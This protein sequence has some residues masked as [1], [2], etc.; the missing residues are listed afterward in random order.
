MKKCLPSLLVLFVIS[1][2]LFAQEQQSLDEQLRSI[3]KSEPFNIAML[4]QSTF[5]YS[6]EDD[7]F[8]GGRT[9]QIPQGRLDF[10]GNLDGGYFY[11]LHTNMVTEPNLLDAYV[12]YKHNDQLILTLGRQKP[13]Q[14]PDFIPG[15]QGTDFMA[16]ARITGFLV[17]FRE[18][19]LSAR[20][21][22]G[23][24]TYFAGIFNG[25]SSPNNVGNNFYGVG[26]LQYTFRDLGPGFLRLGIHGGHGSGTDERA[27]I[28]GGTYFVS[29]RSVIGF[30]AHYQT[31]KW[32]LKGEYMQGWYNDVVLMPGFSFRDDLI[33]GYYIN[34]AYNVS[35]DLKFVGRFQHWMRDGSE[36]NYQ[37][38]LGLIYEATSIV[39]FRVNLDV[40]TPSNGDSQAG[41]GAMMQV[42]F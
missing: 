19:G 11:R 16:R 6:F 39:S 27:S 25:T 24:F 18:F 23:D 1:T 32:K 17:Q 31:D 29:D 20:G 5:R 3:V 41:I 8:L 35:E 12:G 9:F 15:P 34:G 21:T 2:S 30:D 40:Y 38:T 37:S 14:S 42:H 4:F 33:R 28:T 22:K 10:R 7:G 36:T 26:R 13:L